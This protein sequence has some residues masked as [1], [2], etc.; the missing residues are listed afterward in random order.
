MTLVYYHLPKT[1]GRGIITW[2]R[3]SLGQKLLRLRKTNEDLAKRL[4]ETR[5]ARFDSSQWTVVT[6]HDA[7]E[8]LGD[9]HYTAV[10]DPAERLFSQ[11]RHQ[12]RVLKREIG[13]R[14]WHRGERTRLCWCL[15]CNYG[16]THHTANPM[17]WWF[18]SRNLLETPPNEPYFRRWTCSS[19]PRCTTC[20]GPPT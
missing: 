15:W 6:G 9:T 2:M 8:R 3:H 4:F 20:G 5:G 10:R 19:G 12:C 17:A 18:A 7:F 16:V 11:Y 13:W 1:G 14:E